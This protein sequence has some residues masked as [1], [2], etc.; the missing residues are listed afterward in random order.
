MKGWAQIEGTLYALPARRGSETGSY[1]W[2]QAG[3]RDERV[4]AELFLPVVP[5]DELDCAV[6]VAVGTVSDA[7]SSRTGDVTLEFGR[8]RDGRGVVSARGVGLDTDIRFE[9]SHHPPS[10]GFC[11]HCGGEL[12]TAAVE[13]ITPPDGGVIGEPCPR[14]PRCD[15]S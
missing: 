10:G 1:L 6:G 2:V 11:S 5:P 12:E 3:H 9:L 7:A 14:C 4:T 8:V 15:G 13:V